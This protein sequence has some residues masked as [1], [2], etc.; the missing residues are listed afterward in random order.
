MKADANAANK[1]FVF[2]REL[3]LPVCYRLTLVKRTRNSDHEMVKETR[4]QYHLGLRSELEA[5]SLTNSIIFR[6]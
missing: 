3:L 1:L 6:K 2:L 5:Y 4:I